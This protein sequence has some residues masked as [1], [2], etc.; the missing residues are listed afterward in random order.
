[1]RGGGIARTAVA[2]VEDGKTESLLHDVPQAT[3][4]ND[5][6]L[7]AS[8][9]PQPRR[10]GQQPRH[11]TGSRGTGQPRC[12]EL[13]QARRHGLYLQPQPYSVHVPV[14][15]HAAVSRPPQGFE[16][17]QYRVATPAVGVRHRPLDVLALVAQRNEQTRQ[18]RL[19]VGE[20]VKASSTRCGG[21]C[22]SSSG[23]AYSCWCR[24][25]RSNSRGCSSRCIGRGSHA[26]SSCCAC[27]C[28]TCCAN[29][30]TTTRRGW[31]SLDDRHQPR[32]HD[33]F[34]HHLKRSARWCSCQRCCN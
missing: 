10:G 15:E 12:P 25:I 11:V 18:V 1:M 14:S 4:C 19:P 17:V 16:P 28:C 13:P 29:I 20:R 34:K 24:C 22:S 27:R 3:R 5:H 9:M 21:E 31:R 6:P 26:T 33:V 8:E 30:S 23:T 2:V 32:Q 7:L